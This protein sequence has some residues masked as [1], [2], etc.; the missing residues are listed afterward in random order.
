MPPKPAASLAHLAIP[1][2][3]IEIRARPGA[4]RNLLTVAPDGSIRVEV[5]AAPEDGKANAAIRRLLAEVLGVAPSRIELAQGATAR[6][7]R[8]VVLG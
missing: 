2:A 8:F 5:T 4:R 1:G 7:K 3:L 6:T